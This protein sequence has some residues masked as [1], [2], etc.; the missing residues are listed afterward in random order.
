MKLHLLIAG[1]LTFLFASLFINF[2]SYASEFKKQIFETTETIGEK[3]IE[4]TEYINVPKPVVPIIPIFI[5]LSVFV[6]SSIYAMQHSAS[7]KKPRRFYVLGA[8]GDKV[9]FRLSTEIRREYVDAHLS[10]GCNHDFNSITIK[11][12]TRETILKEIGIFCKE[13]GED[14]NEKIIRSMNKER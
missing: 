13:C 1:L 7:K 6:S 9:E 8:C 4:V 14:F 10:L 3:Y 11:D 5:P 12:N 2:S